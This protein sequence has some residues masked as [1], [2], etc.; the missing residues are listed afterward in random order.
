MNIIV[1]ISK[2]IIILPISKAICLTYIC[3]CPLQT[4]FEHKEQSYF[5]KGSFVYETDVVV[6]PFNNIGRDRKEDAEVSSFL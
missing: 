2:V 1:T 5:K 4:F 3:K 6:S